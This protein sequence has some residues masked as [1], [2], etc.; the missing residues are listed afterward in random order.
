MN[1]HQTS[2]VFLVRTYM[3]TYTS[4]EVQAVFDVDHPPS[5]LDWGYTDPT[6]F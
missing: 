5:W 6:V 3:Y 4:G 2:S 1:V